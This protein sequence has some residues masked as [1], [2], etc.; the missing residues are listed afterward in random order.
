M[1]T[2]S[3]QFI[4]EYVEIYKSF[5]C[6]Y[7]IKSKDYSSKQLKDA[8]YGKFSHFHLFRFKVLFLLGKGAI[9]DP[10]RITFSG[11]NTQRNATSVH[12]HEMP[13]LSRSVGKPLSVW[14]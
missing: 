2:W 9:A 6:L 8:A 11:Y 10:L 14:V 12:T 5:P 13:V 4:A 3:T 1:R 7:N